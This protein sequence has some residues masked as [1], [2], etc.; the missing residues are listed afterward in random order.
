LKTVLFNRFEFNNNSRVY[1]N[2]KIKIGLVRHYLDQKIYKLK[3]NYEFDIC[4]YKPRISINIKKVNN[5]R[6]TY[7]R[8]CK[9]F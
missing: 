5:I 6:L 8:I 9:L 7:K 3:N 1:L 4:Y 2:E